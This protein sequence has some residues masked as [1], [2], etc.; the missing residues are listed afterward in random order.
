MPGAKFAFII[1]AFMLLMVFAG[2]HI[3]VAPGAASVIG[4]AVVTGNAHVALSL[5]SSA[6]FEALRDYIFAVIPLFVLMG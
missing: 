3:V 5:L 6:T 1:L 2:F 4:I